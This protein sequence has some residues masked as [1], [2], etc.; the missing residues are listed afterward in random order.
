[1]RTR[2]PDARRVQHA[3]ALAICRSQRY[4]GDIRGAVER[5]VLGKAGEVERL[6]LE[7]EDATRRADQPGGKQAVVAV[8]SSHVDAA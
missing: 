8:M 4:R 6:R 1:M 2:S 3:S 7:G 5:D